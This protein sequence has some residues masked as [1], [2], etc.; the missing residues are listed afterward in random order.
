[1]DSYPPFY[2]SMAPI[3]PPTRAIR[4]FLLS[5]V[6]GIL[7]I[8]NAAFLLSSG[9]YTFWSGI[10]P[11]IPYFGAFPPW[12][13]VIIG[14]IFAVIVFVGSTLMVLGNGTIGAVVV[15]PAAVLSLIFGGGFIAG[16]VL[17][18]IGSILGML[19]R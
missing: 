9:F 2:S 16:F 3:T 11:W 6:S 10:F 15:L 12:M 18:I 19:G 14:I 7:I 5:L 4:G 17:G 1:M 13:L 8:L